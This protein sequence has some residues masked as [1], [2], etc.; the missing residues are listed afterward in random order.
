MTVDKK[1]L[2]VFYGCTACISVIFETLYIMRQEDIFIAL[3]MWT[4]GVVGIVCSKVFYPGQ[5]ALG[6]PGKPKLKYILYGMFI[7]VIYLGVSYFIAWGIVGNPI[8]IVRILKMIPFFIP[9]L[10]ISSITAAGEEIGWRGFAYPVLERM[11]GPAKAVVFNGAFW[12]LWHIPLIIGGVYEAD[13]HPVYGVIAFF[14]EIM[15]IT[16]VFCW[17]RSA[18]GSVIPAILLHA[19]HNLADQVC[20]Q[21]LSADARVPY[22]AGEQGIITIIA[23]AVIAAMVIRNWKNNS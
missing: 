2:T 19:S 15:I 21:P 8:D 11:F 9:G 18:G 3:L 13:T 17:S 4:P 1:A 6:F 22:L 12:A 10:L 7:P 23:A 20:F 14:V 5:K 16:V